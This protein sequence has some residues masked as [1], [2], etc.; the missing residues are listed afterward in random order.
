MQFGQRV[1]RAW[2]AGGVAVGA[3]ALAHA[4]NA[5]VSAS[6]MSSQTSDLQEVV[7]TAQKRAEHL[8][9][10]PVAVTAVTSGQLQSQG[11]VTV[12]DLAANVPGLQVA[13]GIGSG[14]VVLRGVT[15][16]NDINPTVGTQID[17]V[18]VGAAA[19]GAASAASLPELDPSLLTQVEV[20]R[21][22]QGT[23][24]GSS[25]LGGIVNYVTRRPSL[26]SLSGSFYAEGSTTEHG[27]PSGSVRGLLSAP[28]MEDRVG[29][30]V[31]AFVND[32][33]GYI[34]RVGGGQRDFNTNRSYGG[35][36]ALMADV[37]PGLELELSDLYSKVNSTQDLVIYDQVTHAPVAGD[38]LYGDPILPRYDNRYNLL[39][40]RAEY[41]LPW[42]TFTS[43]TGYQTQRAANVLD[44]SASRLAV[45]AGVYL[46][47]Y[48]GV[49]LPTPADP[50][51]RVDLNTDKVTQEFRLTSKG[52]TRLTWIAGLFF[53]SERS[54]NVQT[55][56][57]YGASGHL[58]A[59]PAG[60]LLRYDL[61][62]HYKEYAAFGN[63]TY[64][65][66][67]ALDITGG[68]RVQKINQDYRQL[69]SGSDADAL[70]AL[71]VDSGLGSTPPDSGLSRAS[72]TVV[73]YLANA[74]YR[75]SPGNMVYF[76]FATGFRPG[77]PNILVPGLPPTFKPDTTTDYE[78]GWKTRFWDGKAFLDLSVYDIRWD[79]IQV[80][81]FSNGINGQTNGGRATIRGA[82]ASLTLAPITGLTLS[83]SV[84]YA[85][86]KLDET[87]PG[88]L[89]DKGDRMPATPRWSGALS[90]EYA[91]AVAGDWKAFGG[92][93]A[94]FVGA[95]TYGFAHNVIYA[96]YA[97]PSY[98]L[99][100]LRAGVRRG[101]LEFSA[102]LRNAGD[103]RAQL[104]VSTLG[105]ITVDV[106]RPRTFGLAISA[107]Y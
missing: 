1:F 93:S 86:G 11:V 78:L 58:V 34:D 45:I 27:G 71:Y 89:G 53:N 46:P 3:V 90:G 60:N 65:I 28:L 40:A 15:S 76:R 39:T 105:G 88:G 54:A 23:L 81:T 101:D 44:F 84:T 61:L 85:D 48:G 103:E 31:S 96:Q 17:G 80:I 5:A 7:V 73:T 16:G 91:W 24:Y 37:A 62:T 2:L 98:A 30:L 69:Y 20:L 59:G 107:K 35:T 102:F 13:G 43:I 8:S 67:P 83:G 50:G 9:D 95:R 29:V 70:N 38:L 66:T 25:T 68:L 19:F 100:N 92:F 22:P 64:A 97:M 42:A 104:G 10:A 12:R 14:S 72:D 32:Q 52:N 41:A 94:T 82:E 33:G 55:I 63:V 75:V 79:D 99:V 106:Q 74:R 77:G 51:V 6:Q 49:T 4:A 26:Q 87:I 47:L 56:G 18:P 57:S 36:V 21:G